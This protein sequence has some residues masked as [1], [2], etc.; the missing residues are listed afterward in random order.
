ME[1]AALL[2]LSRFKALCTSSSMIGDILVFSAEHTVAIS[3]TSAFTSCLYL[4]SK[5]YNE[6]L[7]VGRLDLTYFLWR[8]QWLSVYIQ[9]VGLYLGRLS[10]VVNKL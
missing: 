5:C 2:L 4:S 3:S 10:L 7:I 6:I 1:S 8:F 9:G